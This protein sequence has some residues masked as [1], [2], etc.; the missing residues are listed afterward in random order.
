MNRT[1]LNQLAEDVLWSH[2]MHAF[3]QRDWYEV[4]EYLEELWRRVPSPEKDT[5]QGLL[6][7][8][9]C[10][11]HYGNG[12]FAGARLLASGARTRLQRSSVEYRGR[13][14]GGFLERFVAVTRPLLESE[15]A[16]RPLK[17][18][19]APILQRP[20]GTLG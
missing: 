2:A 13:D 5:V 8:A 7:A 14:L 15:S 11:Y 9:V 6:Q 20:E 19:D 4:H 16:L 12:N 10:L 18:A 3:S 1:T 17:P